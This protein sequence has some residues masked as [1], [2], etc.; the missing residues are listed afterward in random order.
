M[1]MET[2]Q[3]GA[4]A[5]RKAVAAAGRKAFGQ[6]VA[7][8]RRQAGMTQEDLAAAVEP[9]GSMAQSTIAKIE[10]GARPT[11][12]EEVAA[13]ARALDLSPAVL[14]GMESGPAELS[15]DAR[16]AVRLIRAALDHKRELYRAAERANESGDKVRD[17]PSSLV[18]SLPARWRHEAGAVQRDPADW[19]ARNW[20][21][22]Q[23]LEQQV[24]DQT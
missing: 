2:N 24:E 18:E 1:L 16:A 5:T 11:P 19:L 15:P 10:R 21:L 23:D 4:A 14:L 8:H 13:L 3:E 17:L 20:A 7:A 9:I 22:G 6:A 12:A